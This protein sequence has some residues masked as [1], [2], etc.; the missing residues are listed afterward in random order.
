MLRMCI[1]QQC[2]AL[3]DE[4]TENA[5]YDSYAIRTF[6]G[7]DLSREA[8]PDAMTLI[9]FRRLL[10]KHQLTERI[11]ASIN[12]H[13]EARGLM[14]R[15]GTVVDATIVAAPS[16]TKNQNGQGDP[17][18]HQSKKGNQWHFGMKAHIDVDVSS[19]G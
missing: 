7:V 17:D 5:I 1:A 9:K 15:E 6:V 10:E 2:F 18:M 3:S 14:L 12:G 8:V 4:A 11:F 19:R 13:L 16:F